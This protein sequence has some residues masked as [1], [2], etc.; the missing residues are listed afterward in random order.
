VIESAGDAAERAASALGELEEAAVRSVDVQ[1]HPPL[2]GDLDEI[3]ERI[4]RPRVGRPGVAD[5]TEGTEALAPVGVHLGMQ[6][7]DVDPEIRC[8]RDD[9]HVALWEPGDDRRL[10]HRRVGMFGRVQ[11]PVEEVRAEQRLARRHDGRQIRDR[12]AGREDPERLRRVV[13]QVREPAQDGRL[14]LRKRR[15]GLPHVDEPVHRERDVGGDRRR[16]QP[17]AGD[18]PEEARPPGLDPLRRCFQHRREHL[19]ERLAELGSLLAEAG[20]EL[21]RPVA[22]RGWRG[23]EPFDELDDRLDGAAGHRAHLLGRRFE[24]ERLSGHAFS[25][26]RATHSPVAASTPAGRSP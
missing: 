7:L 20:R 16:V 22:I 24:R 4:D 6:R 3:D 14:D 25:L 8:G 10:H 19:V 21:A 9:P 18:E 2:V 13:E 12:A 11:R 1:P 23:R 5:H 17:A 26:D 15:R